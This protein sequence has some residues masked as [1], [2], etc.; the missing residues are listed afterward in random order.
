ML[1]NVFKKLNNVWLTR[2]SNRWIAKCRSLYSLYSLRIYPT[3]MLSIIV[4]FNDDATIKNKCGVSCAGRWKAL[5]WVPMS[6]TS[7]TEEEQLFH[8]LRNNEKVKL[9]EESLWR[10]ELESRGRL[11]WIRHNVLFLGSNS[12]NPRI[13]LIWAI[14]ICQRQWLIGTNAECHWQTGEN[15]LQ[16][17]QRWKFLW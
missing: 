12:S 1:L 16:W 8:A 13:A 3:A 4:A 10:T 6:S 15:T 5:E 2:R 11:R 7:S 9:L 14:R 17:D